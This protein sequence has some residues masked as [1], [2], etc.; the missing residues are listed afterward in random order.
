MRN[1]DLVS[2]IG[3]AL[4]DVEV[5]CIVDAHCV[6]VAAA[7]VEPYNVDAPPMSDDTFVVVGTSSVHAIVTENQAGLL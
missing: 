1:L 4:A 2:C 3:V 6:V 7:A 5:H